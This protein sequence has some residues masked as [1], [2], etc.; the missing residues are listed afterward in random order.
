MKKM[1]VGDEKII[2]KICFAG[3]LKLITPLIIGAGNGEGRKTDNS[4]T[5]SESNVDSLILKNKQ[6][7]PFI[8]ATSLAGVLKNALS[9]Y[10]K[11][12]LATVFGTTAKEKN[13][14]QSSIT[15]YD[16]I[17][18][19]AITA[20][21][22]GVCIDSVTGVA[23]KGGKYDFEV[24]EV[25]ATGKFEAVFTLRQ[26]HQVCKGLS[27]I[28]NS[29][30]QLLVQGFRV[31]AK[32]TNGLGMVRIAEL[33]VDEYDFTKV[34]DVKAWLAPGGR[35]SAETH[36][37]EK[38]T[39]E[40]HFCGEEDFAVEMEFAL[41]HSLIVRDYDT[42]EIELPEDPK[43]RINA[44]SMRSHDG[45]FIIPGSSLKGVIRHQ[46]VDVL[47]RMGKQ[48]IADTILQ[49]IFGNPDSS[50]GNKAD[51]RK[52][53]LFVDEITFS[54]E[55]VNEV[56]QSRNRIDRFTG[57]TIDSALFHEKALWQKNTAEKLATLKFVLKK[58]NEHE[59]GLLLFVL[60]D[61]WCGKV[62]F[63]GEKSIG[64]GF[65]TGLSL[66]VRYSGEEYKIEKNKPVDSTVVVALEKYAAAI[67]D[68][69]EVAK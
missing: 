18:K 26:G 61:I 35:Q 32:T 15:F 48:S 64:R 36:Y 24:V 12:D 38:S 28:I 22:D 65:V 11:D 60:R 33:T 4:K 50:Q 39:S 25:G 49:A 46:A 3:E 31:G 68:W 13:G 17:L 16:V 40:I 41:K 44:V 14:W 54:K 27:Q 30:C 42:A 57:G 6:G 7:Q 66:T 69:T 19:N 62:A 8:P 1:N 21:R 23:K 55:K 29:F 58:A 51:S 47:R 56:T 45:T 5:G 10:D 59:I 67:N 20:V 53:R 2:G 37:T 63:G 9:G 34:A 43:I 52:G